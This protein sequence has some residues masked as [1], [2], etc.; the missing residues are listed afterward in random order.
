[1]CSYKW[2]SLGILL[3]ST[4]EAFPQKDSG[5]FFSQPSPKINIS[6][7]AFQEFPQP[8]FADRLFAAIPSVPQ[9]WSEDF[10]LGNSPLRLIKKRIWQGDG[11]HDLLEC[12]HLSPLIFPDFTWEFGNLTNLPVTAKRR[13]CQECAQ[14]LGL[15]AK[16][17]SGGGAGSGRTQISEK[18]IKGSPARVSPQRKPTREP[19]P[20]MGIHAT[21]K[22]CSGG[23][24][25]TD[26]ILGG[27]S[28]SGETGACTASGRLSPTMNDPE[29]AHDRHSS[30]T[31]YDSC[32]ELL[33]LPPKKSSGSEKPKPQERAG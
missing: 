16:A 23:D 29:D 32:R 14:A 24:A 33:S 7:F 20:L 19:V 3:S 6:S 12:G 13:R 27:R 26:S 17:A 11:F 18:L 15:A 8:F 9:E 5:P 21:P 2:P 25:D 22:A 30:G 31:L 28:E 1:V 10:T 4:I